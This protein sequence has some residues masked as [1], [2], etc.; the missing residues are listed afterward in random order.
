V[1]TAAWLMGTAVWLIA[2]V[3]VR[4]LA[5]VAGA[6]AAARAETPPP[7]L[8]H[9]KLDHP[10]HAVRADLDVGQV[11]LVVRDLTSPEYAVVLA[12]AGVSPA[13]VGR[14]LTARDSIAATV[15]HHGPDAIMAEHGPLDHPRRPHAV[16][17]AAAVAFDTPPGAI[18]IARL[19][20]TPPLTPA[21]LARV[22]DRLHPPR[23]RFRRAHHAHRP[24]WKHARAPADRDLDLRPVAITVHCDERGSDSPARPPRSY[25][26]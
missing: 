13:V 3:A 19:R 8:C 2:V 11:L 21:D 4:R 14:A 26:S 5:M 7:P 15:V 1:S 24:H 18:A 10:V 6:H 22:R 12:G 17:H 25:Y 16:G 9:A 23:R 20:A